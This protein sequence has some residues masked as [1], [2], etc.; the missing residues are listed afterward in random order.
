MRGHARKH[1]RLCDLC[2]DVL[3]E[4]TS[5]I[6][7]HLQVAWSANLVGASVSTGL[8]MAFKK[9]RNGDWN[10]AGVYEKDATA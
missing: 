7:D 2:G 4:E 9:Q 1:A 3:D 8:D 6:N 5:L 10:P